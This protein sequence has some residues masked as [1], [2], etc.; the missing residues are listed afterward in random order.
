VQEHA[1]SDGQNA[2]KIEVTGRLTPAAYLGVLGLT[3]LT[4]YVGLLDVGRLSEGETVLGSGAAGGVGMAV[5]QIAKVKGATA[6]RIGRGPSC[7]ARHVYG[8]R[9][10]PI[11]S[12]ER[13]P[14]GS[15]GRFRQGPSRA[16]NRDV[17]TPTSKTSL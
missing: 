1:V 13:S 8:V 6:V 11:S 5:G 14:P 16:S 15:G 9:D 17:A 10:G 2:C 7:Y 4:A 12:T 3:G